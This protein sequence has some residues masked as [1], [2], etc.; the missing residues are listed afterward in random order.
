MPTPYA[1]FAFKFKNA[2]VTCS[3]QTFFLDKL[4]A[5]IK[6]KN[7]YIY[8]NNKFSVLHSNTIIVSTIKARLVDCNKHS[9]VIDILMA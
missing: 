6:K 7:I 8:I 1:V 3:D 5:E 4:H 9:S 2:I